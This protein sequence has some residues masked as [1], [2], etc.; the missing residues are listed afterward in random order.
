VP[1][2]TPLRAVSA[3]E[4]RPKVPKTLL[5]AAGASERTLLVALRNSIARE[6]DGGVP[7]HALAP[8]ARQLRDIAKEI[9]AI[10]LR[11]KE[12]ASEDGVTP[13]EEWD[14]EAL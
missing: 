2:K 5:E 12:E 6:I 14:A 13:D 11:A 1:A 3:A 8:L 10:D 7:A 4:R 9:E